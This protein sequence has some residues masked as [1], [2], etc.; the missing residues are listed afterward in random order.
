MKVVVKG[1]FERAI[2]LFKRKTIEEGIIYDK[3]I[4]KVYFDYDNLFYII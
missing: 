4:S 3:F 1:N 2:R